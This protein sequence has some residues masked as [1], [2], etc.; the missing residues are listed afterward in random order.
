[1][2]GHVTSGEYIDILPI[3]GM[4]G[5]VDVGLLERKSSPPRMSDLT[6]FFRRVSRSPEEERGESKLVS[7]ESST[8]KEQTGETGAGIEVVNGPRDD[9]TINDEVEGDGEGSSGT[10]R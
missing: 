10:K 5:V 4:R 2:E 7:C 6:S 3:L 1:M 8:V 9:E